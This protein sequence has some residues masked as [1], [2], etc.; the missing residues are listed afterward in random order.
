MDSMNDAVQASLFLLYQRAWVSLNAK[1]AHLWTDHQVQ[2]AFCLLS[3]PM[4]SFIDWMA[5]RGFSTPQQEEEP[6]DPDIESGEGWAIAHTEEGKRKIEARIKA[7]AEAAN[8]TK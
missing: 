2:D 6:A 5:K 1:D 3:P 4:V 8:H 7:L